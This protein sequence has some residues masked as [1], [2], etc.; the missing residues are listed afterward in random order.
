MPLV[1]KSQEQEQ[2]RAGKNEVRGVKAPYRI[3]RLCRAQCRYWV[4]FD[5]LLTPPYPH[6]PN[7]EM[8]PPQTG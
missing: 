7:S 4:R 8:G 6:P 5:L 1:L 2:D 3:V